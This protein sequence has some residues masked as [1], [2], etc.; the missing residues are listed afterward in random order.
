LRPTIRKCQIRIVHARPTN[1][2]PVGVNYFL[3]E[4]LGSGRRRKEQTEG[5]DTVKKLRNEFDL[6]SLCPPVFM[7]VIHVTIGNS[8]SD[9]LH[10][11]FEAVLDV[12]AQIYKIDERFQ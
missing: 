10:D 4:L 8:K 7:F 12:H 2:L 9:P 6:R 1:E 3:A 11:L 5:Y